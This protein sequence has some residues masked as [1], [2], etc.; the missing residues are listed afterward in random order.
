MKICIEMLEDTA[1]VA[2]LAAYAFAENKPLT[3]DTLIARQLA[4]VLAYNLWPDTN[5]KPPMRMTDEPLPECRVVE[6]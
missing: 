3:R 5:P 2:A 4:E 1:R 6:A